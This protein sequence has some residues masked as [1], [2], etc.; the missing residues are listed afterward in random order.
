MYKCMNLHIYRCD[1]HPLRSTLPNCRRP[2][3]A[4]HC[5]ALQH[6]ATH[7][8]TKSTTPF[9]ACCQLQS[10]PH[11]TRYDALQ[12][13]ATGCSTLQHTAIHCNILQHTATHYNTLQHTEAHCT[14]LQHTAT[15]YNAL[16]YIAT[17]CNTL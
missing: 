12:H 6:T 2:T 1:V 9:P 3:S 11:A 14:T 5:N 16:Q 17:Y 15:L 8:N 4:P 7:C 10:G 13:V